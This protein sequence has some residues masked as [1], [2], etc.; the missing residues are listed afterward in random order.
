MIQSKQKIKASV[1]LFVIAFILLII[2]G[3]CPAVSKLKAVS[4]NLSEQKGKFIFLEEQIKV[5]DD[6]QKSDSVYQ[7][8]INKL[9]TSFIYAQAPIE[10]IEFLEKEA[11]KNNLQ[12]VISSVSN[13]SEK[14]GSRLIMVFQATFSGSF[15]NVYNF[16]RKIEQSPWLIKID[17]ATIERVDESNKSLE[18]ENLKTGKVI[19]KLNFQT[20]SNYL[21][22]IQR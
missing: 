14:K 3:V 15:P 17:Q 12:A 8:H 22:E 19:L 21:G 7:Q 20:F 2:F 11:S 16:L 4:K 5:L 13:V 18:A 6:F 1:A 9:N 10:F